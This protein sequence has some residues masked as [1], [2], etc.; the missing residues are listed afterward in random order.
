[1][2]CRGMLQ[3]PHYV[4]WINVLRGGLNAVLAWV[5]LM[6]CILTYTVNWEYDE[7]GHPH[8]DHHDYRHTLTTVRPAG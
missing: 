2:L 4:P 5:S 7:K 3:V 6:A 1:M 8:W